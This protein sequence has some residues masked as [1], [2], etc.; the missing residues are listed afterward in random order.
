MNE[1]DQ[2]NSF[3][4]IQYLGLEMIAKQLLFGLFIL[5]T[6]YIKQNF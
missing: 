5:G 6:K 2:L 1:K 4:G 3:A